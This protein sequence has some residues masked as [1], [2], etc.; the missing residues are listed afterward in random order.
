M[1]VFHV[2]PVPDPDLEIR[3]MGVGGGRGWVGC[4]PDPKISGGGGPV[5]KKKFSVWP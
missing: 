2:N 1:G 4:H 3:G 5:F